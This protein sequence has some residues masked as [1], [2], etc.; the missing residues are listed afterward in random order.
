MQNQMIAMNSVANL[1][2]AD[3][4]EAVFLNTWGKLTVY[5]IPVI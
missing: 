5:Q 3:R 2:S 1:S 4:R